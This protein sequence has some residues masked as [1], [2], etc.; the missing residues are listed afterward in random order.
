MKILIFSH[1]TFWGGAEKAL[2]DLVDHLSLEH[3]VAIMFPHPQGEFVEICRAKRIEIGFMP[4]G[5]SIPNPA[6]FLIDFYQLDLDAYLRDFRNSKFDFVIANTLATLQGVLIANMLN[7]PCLVYAHEYLIPKEGLS[8]HGCS[9][10]YYLQMY[11]KGADHILCATKYVQSSFGLTDPSK[12]SVLYPFSPYREPALKASTHD[13]VSLLVIGG[14]LIRKNTH[15]ALMV[16][17]ALRLRGINADLHIVGTDGDGTFKLNQQRILRQEHNVYISEHHPNP[18]ALG[19][20]KKINL[21]CALNE[22][23]GLTMTEA[24][25]SGIPV[26]SSRCGGPEEVLPNE[27]LYETNNLDECVRSVENII[28]NYDYYC[29]ASKNLYENFIKNSNNLELRKQTINQA[30][31]IAS[32]NFKKKNGEFKIIESRFKSILNLPIDY[33]ELISNIAL[34]SQGTDR[35]LTISEV[36][37]LIKL[38]QQTPGANVLKD[39]IKF[40]VVPFAYSKKMDQLYAKGLGLAIELATYSKSLTKFQIQAYTLL[41]LDSEQSVASLK[42]KVLFLG[43]G[44]GLDSIKIAQSG[45]DVDYLDFDTSLMSKCASLNI[46]TARKLNSGININVINE[47]SQ[48][49][50]VI[51]CFEVIEHVSDPSEF[52]KFISESLNSNGIVLISECFD[53]VYDIWP[54]HLYANEQFSASL[55]LMMA[56]FF[57]L[58]DINTQPNGKPYL[59][60]KKSLN[61]IDNKSYPL[62]SKSSLVG[63]FIHLKSKIGY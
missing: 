53:G 37:S 24:L 40:D 54:T 4:L 11:L 46:N 51:I 34:A 29:E 38:E 3:E 61:I 23:F 19:G 28:S 48:K 59:F 9:A 62:F 33:Q 25:C 56:P 58:D 35:P 39:V 52:I 27:F 42:L 18:F 26:I 50:D 41:A 55:E 12:L 7:V 13:G 21:I 15:F 45:F 22:P 20:A 1:G 32:S 6:N 31:E 44:I 63:S 2:M 30:I 60:R 10:A 36:S 14:K 47:L 17:K 5:L 8:P 16:L 49:Y 43:D 57:Y